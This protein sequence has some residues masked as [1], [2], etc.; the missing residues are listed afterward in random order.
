MCG[1]RR[2]AHVGRSVVCFRGVRTLLLIAVVLLFRVCIIPRR[3]GHIYYNVLDHAAGLA[4][5]L[6]RLLEEQAAVREPY[7]CLQP[8]RADSRTV[9]Y[10]TVPKG[11]KADLSMQAACRGESVF[12]CQRLTW[13]R[14]LR[15]VE[16]VF[17]A[18]DPGKRPA[19]GALI[20]PQDRSSQAKTR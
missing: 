9:V 14:W 17:G 4:L 18:K 15:R 16:S 7:R 1:V 11:R 5:S 10:P 13:L 12:V 2:E 8:C 6:R 20:P 19:G 3:V